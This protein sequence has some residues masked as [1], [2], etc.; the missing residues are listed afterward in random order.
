MKERHATKLFKNLRFYLKTF[1]LFVLILLFFFTSESIDLAASRFFFSLGEKGLAFPHTKWMHYLFKLTPWPAILLGIFCFILFVLTPFF[2]K[3]K[4]HRKTLLFLWLSFAMGPG[5]ITHIV[6]KEFYGRPRPKHVIE[7]GGTENYRAFYDPGPTFK[8]KEHFRS[9]PCGH[10]TTG[11]YYFVFGFWLK[12]RHL[13]QLSRM[14]FL[15]SFL[16]GTA[17]GVLRM[18]QGG[19][20]F[21][22]VVAGGALMWFIAWG[23]YRILYEKESS[24][25]LTQD[26]DLVRGS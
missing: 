17:I 5:F 19:H 18:A 23:L 14:V 12:K 1:I 11:Y 13:F 7:F 10:C 24:Y 2:K 9:F 25:P 20:F 4:V 26:R 22:D 8:E 21:S 15:F 6:F 16:Y 3:L